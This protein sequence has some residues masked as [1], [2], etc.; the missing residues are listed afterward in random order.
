MQTM[1]AKG[2][3]EDAF[4]LVET[5][6]GVCTKQPEAEIWPVLDLLQGH[7]RSA[8]HTLLVE[9]LAHRVHVV[10]IPIRHAHQLL[11]EELGEGAKL[12]ISWCEGRLAIK[13]E[14]ERERRWHLRGVLPGRRGRLG[15]SHL[16][17][18]SY[19]GRTEACG[20]GVLV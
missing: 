15:T 14:E 8:I 18:Q 20:A 12:W 6:G 9:E 13:T 16:A 17:T 2:C 3:E 4:K 19:K 5:G 10:G 7:E 11:R 1:A